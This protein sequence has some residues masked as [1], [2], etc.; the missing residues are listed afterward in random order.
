MRNSRPYGYAWSKLRSKRRKKKVIRRKV[1]VTGRTAFKGN[2]LSLMTLLRQVNALW[3]E[4]STSSDGMLGDKAHRARKSDHNP[5]SRGIVQ[6][7]DITHDPKQGCD[8]YKIAEMLQVNKDHRIKYVI[9]N[10]KIMSGEEQTNPAWVWREYDGANPHNKH[11]HI[12]VRDDPNLYNDAG[13][14]SLDMIPPDQEA[15]EIKERPIL[16][17]GDQGEAVKDLQ[18]LLGIEED[19]DFGRGTERAVKA[20]QKRHKLVADGVCGAY[21]WD[22]LE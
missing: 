22:V 19:G 13:E 14:W 10:R 21:T 9:S 11:V 16:R 18:H 15:P 1:P 5:N 2:A 17:Q 4:R 20:L 6:A 12:S 3:P 7:L 8:S